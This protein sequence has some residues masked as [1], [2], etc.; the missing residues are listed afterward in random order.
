M[1]IIHPNPCYDNWLVTE[2]GKKEKKY[3]VYLMMVDEVKELKEQKASFND[4]IKYLLES[5]RLDLCDILEINHKDLNEAEF[6]DFS[7]VKQKLDG[8]IEKVDQQIFKTN[9]EYREYLK[10]VRKDLKINYEQGI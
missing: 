3:S 4:S 9:K 2:E 10:K 6:G 1:E 7:S 8:Y 5:L